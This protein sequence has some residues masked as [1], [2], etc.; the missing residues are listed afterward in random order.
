[1]KTL[2]LDESIAEAERFLKR[3]RALRDLARASKDPVMKLADQGHV[4]A[5]LYQ[6]PAQQGAVKRASMDLTRSLARLR[7]R[8][9]AYFSQPD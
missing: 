6:W 7:A 9:S 2:A 4:D 1:M 8:D 3:A 5:W